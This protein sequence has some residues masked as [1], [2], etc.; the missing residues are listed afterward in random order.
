MA[1][2]ADRMHR[3]M[4]TKS[5]GFGGEDMLKT[6]KMNISQI[7]RTMMKVLEIESDGWESSV[8]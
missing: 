5:V 2:D 8:S 7:T 6:P 1:A 4:T 3:K